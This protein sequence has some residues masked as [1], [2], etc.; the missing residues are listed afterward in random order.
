MLSVSHNPYLHRCVL[1]CINHLLLGI[2]CQRL[3]TDVKDNQHVLQVLCI[4]YFYMK[5]CLWVVN[6]QTLASVFFF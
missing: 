3:A 5:Q 6:K 2:N 1:R 4:M